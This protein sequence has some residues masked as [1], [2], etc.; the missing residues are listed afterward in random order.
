MCCLL[1]RPN[2]GHELGLSCFFFSLL[3][4]RARAAADGPSC[5]WKLMAFRHCWQH[6]PTASDASGTPQSVGTSAAPVCVAG[7]QGNTRLV[8]GTS[9]KGFRRNPTFLSRGLTA[10]IPYF[11]G[12]SVFPGPFPFSFLLSD[13]LDRS[14]PNLLQLHLAGFQEP[15]L[16]CHGP[17]IWQKFLLSEPK[18]M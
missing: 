1:L 2:Q 5:A 3:R 11:L 7:L 9:G 4:A 10:G 14:V 16:S 18:C 17:H 12:L 8:T 13:Y 6:C 15:S